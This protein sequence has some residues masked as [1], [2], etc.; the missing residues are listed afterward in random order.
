[1]KCWTRRFFR[2]PIGPKRMKLPTGIEGNAMSAERR[3]GIPKELWFDLARKFQGSEL[4]EH[5]T[6]GIYSGEPCDTAK[7]IRTAF[8]AGV[9]VGWAEKSGKV[10]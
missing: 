8:A 7:S 10:K 4:E 2:K 6:V 5:V 1:M 3:L 9:A